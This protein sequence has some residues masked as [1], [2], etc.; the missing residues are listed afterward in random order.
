MKKYDVTTLD[1]MNAEYSPKI[2]D[3]YGIKALICDLDYETIPA[4]DDSL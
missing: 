1:Q 3:R 2:V 4:T